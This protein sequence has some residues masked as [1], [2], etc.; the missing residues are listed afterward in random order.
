MTDLLIIESKTID[1]MMFDS[2][3]VD[4]MSIDSLTI[5]LIESLTEKFVELLIE[6]SIE[7]L[8]ESFIAF[9]K[10]AV[11]W[12]AIELI[13]K[14]LIELIRT[15][16]DTFKIDSIV[17]EKW[18]NVDFKI[19][20]FMQT[21]NRFWY[22]ANFDRSDFFSLFRMIDVSSFDAM[23]IW[24]SDF[25]CFERTILCCSQWTDVFDFVSLIDRSNRQL[26]KRRRAIVQFV[27]LLCVRNQFSKL[28][29]N[30]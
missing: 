4:S 12:F 16:I 10:F 15:Y 14:F 26:T 13:E 18:I 5:E 19:D 24:N 3:I 7:T 25:A 28:L 11:D 6:S 27:V 1:S 29:L 20:F 21:V 22:C 23:K 8:I 30:R 9:K 2:I 17:I